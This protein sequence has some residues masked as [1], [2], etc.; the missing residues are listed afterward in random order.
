MRALL[1]L[2]ALVATLAAGEPLAL[3]APIRSVRV[4]PDE[5]WV[6]RIGSLTLPAAGTFKLKLGQLPGGL[7]LDDLRIQAKGPG[8]TR[9]G[10]IQVGPDRHVVPETP[11]SKA[12]LAR[13]EA[14]HARKS[15]L[16]SLQEANGKSAGFLEG[17][18][19]QQR[20]GEGKALP[21]GSA[22][23]EL[24]RGLEARLAELS[25]Q[26]QVR[27][28][29][30]EKVQKEMTNL[31]AEWQKLRGKLDTNPNPSVVTVEL[32]T[33]QSGEVELEVSYRTRQARWKPSYESRLSPD[34][35]RLEL[36]LFAAV[37]QASG[38]SWDKVRMELSNSAPSR[39]QEMPQFSNVAGLGWRAPAVSFPS[40]PYSGSAT[41]EVVGSSVA[42]DRTSTM[43]GTQIVVHDSR[44]YQPPAPKP[45]PILEPAASTLEE[46]TGLAKA[47][48]L[49]GAKDVP[50]DGDAHRFRVALQE[51]EPTV[52]IVVAPRLDTTAYQ[53][54]R[55]PAPT[56]VPLFPGAPILRYVGTQRMGQGGFAVPPAG[57]PFELNYGPYE[58]LRSSFQRV[59]EKRPFKMSKIVGVLTRTGG[60]TRTETREEIT[61]A[62]PERTWQLEERLTLAN[63]TEAPLTVE[64]QD[65]VVRSVHESVRIEATPDTTPGAVL[66][67]PLVQAWTLRLEPKATASLDTGL[68]IKA[69]KEGEL[70]GLKELGLE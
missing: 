31:E 19:N 50:S 8:G 52:H 65:R 45:R 37:T 14:L 60:V 55:F 16:E 4:H 12:L 69:P 53:V 32:D 28:R 6:T 29:E 27:G 24:T 68:V 17:F 11:E 48:L 10:E 51:L 26:A 36:V 66:R 13:L 59:G 49:D 58:G 67:S 63:D 5:A 70:T 35:K 22:L 18:M 20:T 57:Q 44:P 61:T 7:V 47:W 56:K 41:V 62:T 30:L 1:L 9:L 15:E 33:D 43:L 64:V 39:V 42:V 34:G 54:V 21:T 23:I 3:T 25:A 46:A 38:E 2:P 40:G